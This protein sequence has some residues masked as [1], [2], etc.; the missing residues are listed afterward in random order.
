MTTPQIRFREYSEQKRH[1]VQDE[2][3]KRYANEETARSNRANEAIRSYANEI[4]K[5]GIQTQAATSKYAANT[6]AAASKYAANTA[7]AASRYGATVGAAA[8]RYSADASASASKYSTDKL[9]L[10]NSERNKISKFEAASNRLATLSRNQLNSAQAKQ[11]A[12]TAEKTAKE[13]MVVLADYKLRAREQDNKDALRKAEIVTKYIQTLASAYRNI[14]AG[15]KDFIDYTGI[16]DIRNLFL[17]EFKN[18]VGGSGSKSSF[19][20]DDPNLPF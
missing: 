8:T 7:A 3:L 20:Y 11:Y 14:H 13:A 1:N 5:Y 19:S 12:A 4:S 15:N 17:Q 2:N 9:Y 6:S 16:K 10:T 18:L